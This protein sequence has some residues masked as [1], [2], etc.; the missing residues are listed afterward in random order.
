V[1]T[2]QTLNLQLDNVQAG[3]GNLFTEYV[4]TNVAINNGA[5]LTVNNVN[6]PSACGGIY[7]YSGAGWESAL[8]YSYG[9]YSFIAKS[10]NVSGTGLSL[11]AAGNGTI[12]EQIGFVFPGSSPRTVNVSSWHNNGQSA[13][14]LIQLPFDASAGYHNYSFVYAPTLITFYVDGLLYSAAT[15]NA[16]NATSGATT[17]IIPTGPLFLEVFYGAQP[18]YYGVFSYNGYSH[19]YVS[20]VSFS[21]G[22]PCTPIVTQPP[23]STGGHPSNTGLSTGASSSLPVTTQTTSAAGQLAIIPA[24][25][26][27]LLLVVAMI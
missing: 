24:S 7:N 6:C 27:L 25:I 21:S 17:N 4:P 10:T 3:W 22:A 20:E 18:S 12:L 16:T 9:T 11:V 5:T 2:F 23:S 19:A 26:A 13:E 14:V 1:N 15:I 8:S